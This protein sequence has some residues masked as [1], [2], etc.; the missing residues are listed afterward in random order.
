MIYRSRVS[1]LRIPRTHLSDHVLADARLRGQKEAVIDAAT[2]E[3]LTYQDLVRDA[4]RGAAALAAAGVLPG[5]VVA[6]MSHNQPRF[7]VAVHATLRAGAAVSPLNPALTVGEIVKQ[8]MDSR[9]RV[10]LVAQPFAN[11]GLEAAQRAGMREVFVIGT[12]PEHGSWDELVA[13]V[14][15]A[16]PPLDADPDHAL[17]AL[18]YSSGTTGASKGVMLTHRNIVA[19]LEQLRLA[20]QM[21]EK[22]VLCAALPFFHIYGL[23]IILNAGLLAGA[24]IVTLPRFGLRPFLGAVQRYGV[25]RGHLAPPV[26]LDLAQAAEIDEYDV[27]SMRTAVSGAA[28]LD[29]ELAARAEERIGCVIRQGYGMTEASPGT[30]CVHDEDFPVT[31]P[32]S[33]GRLLPDT[34][35]RLVDPGSG[36]D[37]EPGDAGELWVRGP[38]VMAGYLADSEATAATLTDGWL[39]TGD[40]ARVDDQGNF[41]VVDRLKELIK[42]KGYQVAPAELEAVLLAHPDVADAAVVAVPHPTGGEAPKAF[43][44][45]GRAVAPQELLDWVAARVA[46]YKRI[47]SVEF[48]DAIPKSPAGKI[49]RRKLKNS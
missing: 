26:V 13:G 20:W 19:N 2:G 36:M 46:P 4:D 16:P 18:P 35:A 10:L 5:D 40:I 49:L 7:A 27:S 31:P 38:Q 3:V 14:L 12:Y 15:P 17:A 9:A 8:L 33:V 42:Y 1:G 45:T 32:G 28:P 21:S 11:K 41:F 37:V 24:T 30:H 44:V 22:D 34:E 25:T 48:I 23:T 39:R 43:V 47:R 29:E 6:V